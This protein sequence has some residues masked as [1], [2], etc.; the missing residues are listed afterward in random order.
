M[1]SPDFR[2]LAPS[3]FQT[4]VQMRNASSDTQSGFA[5]LFKSSLI[6]LADNDRPAEDAAT[7]S[8]YDSLAFAM[9]QFQSM[10]MVPV[11]SFRDVLTYCDLFGVVV[12]EGAGVA[13][14]DIAQALNSVVALWQMP[15]PKPFNDFSMVSLL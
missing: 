7:T 1:A 9:K 6:A 3:G 2:A 14:G 4:V 5:Y 15:D 11:G 10:A 12:P 8:L 13:A